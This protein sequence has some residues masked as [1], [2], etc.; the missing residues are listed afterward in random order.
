MF[1][2]GDR[3][4]EARDALV[5]ADGEQD[6]GPL[7]RVHR[8]DVALEVG[9]EVQLAG[10][11]VEVLHAEE[12]LAD[13][14]VAAVHVDV[15]HEQAEGARVDRQRGRLPGSRINRCQSH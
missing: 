15:V 1:A 9:V 5:E 6:L 14:A 12:R 3:D 2:L 10:G 4:R 8:V 7:G 11:E 13:D